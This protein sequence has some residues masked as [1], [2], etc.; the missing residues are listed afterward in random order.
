MFSLY[1]PAL[2]S[3]VGIFLEATVAALFGLGVE[4]GEGDDVAAALL[5]DGT[6]GADVVQALSAVIMTMMNRCV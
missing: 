4:L 6:F 5:L 1:S 2:T 3:D